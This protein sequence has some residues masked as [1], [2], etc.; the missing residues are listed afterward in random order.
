MI[1]RFWCISDIDQVLS[2]E[3]FYG[4]TQ[5][6]LPFYLVHPSGHALCLDTM[7]TKHI[8]CS[9]IPPLIAENHRDLFEI[10][11]AILSLPYPVCPR[12]KTGDLSSSTVAL[13][14]LIWNQSLQCVMSYLFWSILSCA[15]VMVMFVMHVW[16]FHFIL[17]TSF[18]FSS[19]FVLC[20]WLILRCLSNLWK[21]RDWWMGRVDRETDCHVWKTMSVLKWS[22]V[23]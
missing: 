2:D 18:S 11:Q 22:D 20:L 10:L 9:N 4:F 21:R 12:K 15:P 6:N 3:T 5:I 7:Q 1:Q 14:W 16:S 23:S 13:K 17:S 19:F 8:L